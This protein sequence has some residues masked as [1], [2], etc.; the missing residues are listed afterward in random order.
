[1][2]DSIDGKDR[3]PDRYMSAGRETIDRMRDEAHVLADAIVAAGIQFDTVDK[4][5]DALFA[6]HCRATAMKYEDRAGAKG[7]GSADYRKCAWYRAMER[8]IIRGGPDPRAERPD[9]VPY[10][11][12]S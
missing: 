3:A 4:L 8:H 2:S 6:F 11:R 5:A 10:T 7:D 12:P 9:F 1:M